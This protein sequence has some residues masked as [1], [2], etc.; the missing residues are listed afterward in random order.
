[1]SRSSGSISTFILSKSLPANHERRL[2]YFFLDLL[3][4]GE[5][6][7]LGGGCGRCRHMNIE[8]VTSGLTETK[9]RFAREYERRCISGYCA[10][11]EVAP[12]HPSKAVTALF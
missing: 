1:M 2:V 3:S 8:L 4:D 9:D 10:A 12:E 11:D 6:C 5:S 7:G